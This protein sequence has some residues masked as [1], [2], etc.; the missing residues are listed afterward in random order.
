[1]IRLGQLLRVSSMSEV[2]FFSNIIV[3]NNRADPSQ[4]EVLVNE[5][6]GT[7]V[8]TKGSHCNEGGVAAGYAVI[9]HLRVVEELKP[10]GA[11]QDPRATRVLPLYDI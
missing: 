8:R 11:D 2:G 10:A 5:T 6:F 9:D 3:R 7:L 1:M 4:Q